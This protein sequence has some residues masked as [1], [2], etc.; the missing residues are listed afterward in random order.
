VNND[1]FEDLYVTNLGVNRLF[2]NQ[3]GAR[4]EDRAAAAGVAV[5]SWS[6][7]CAFG[8]YDGDGWLDL[9]VAGYV[10]IDPRHLP[11]AP[12]DA[13]GPPR[14]RPRRPADSRR[15]PAASAWARRS[16]PAPPSARIA[17]SRSCAA[18]SACWARP[19]TCSATTA[20]GPSAT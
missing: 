16:R 18:R 10:A 1:G 2:M 17:A 6:T 11:P 4:F 8:D 9:Y 12:P 15:T 5:D 20:T 13:A 7:G 14:R 19:I 3:G